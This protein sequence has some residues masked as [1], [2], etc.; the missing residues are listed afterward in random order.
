[1]ADQSLQEKRFF[2]AVQ[3]GDTALIASFVRTA[4]AL[5]QA[6]A[7]D[8]QGVEDKT[9]LHMAVKASD[10]KTASLLLGLGAPLEAEDRFGATPLLLA[11]QY[12]DKTMAERLV[13]AGADALATTDDGITGAMFAAQGGDIPMLEYFLA[14]GVDV[15]AQRDCGM[16]ALH[17]AR[18]AQ[19]AYETVCC[20][21]FAG[22]DPALKGAGD[23][24]PA[25]LANKMGNPGFGRTI[26][27]AIR[28]KEIRAAAKALTDRQDR[29]V[30]EHGLPQAMTVRKSPLQL[31]ARA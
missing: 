12:R 16:T 7:P 15:N 23:V 8:D 22:A 6:Q 31:R 1:M 21:V 24:T 10:H 5:L 30:L 26:D 19:N 4:P 11:A 2:A 13:D 25:E 20:L 14:K 27:A 9:A 18:N 3:A 29:D 17:F 28:E